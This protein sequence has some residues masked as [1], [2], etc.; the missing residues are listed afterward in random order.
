VADSSL[1]MIGQLVAQMTGASECMAANLYERLLGQ[2]AGHF[3]ADRAILRHYNHT[4][5]NSALIATWPPPRLPAGP[6]VVDFADD[7]V[8]LAAE[9]LRAPAVTVAGESASLMAVAPLLWGPT[10][11]GVVGL[12]KPVE[13]H[14]APEELETL[15]V[16]ASLF[17]QLQARFAAESRLHRLA[18]RDELTGLHNRRALTTEVRRR[19]REGQAGPVAALYID[20]DRLKSVNDRLGHDAGDVVIQTCARRLYTVA[21]QY[22]MVARVGGDE[23]VVVSRAAMSVDEAEAL[24]HSLC[25]AMNRSVYVAGEEITRTV[26]IGLAIGTPGADC[27]DDLLRRADHAALAVKRLGGNAFAVSSQ[28]VPVVS[29]M[30]RE[31]HLVESAELHSRH[32]H[33]ND[34]LSS[35]M[36]AS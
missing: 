23:F 19:L 21:G 36:T 8:M 7:A 35:E 26:S 24:A 10:T 29:R 12:T 33:E 32:Q 1:R 22:G 30:G 3:E 25:D 14:W 4:L 16:V 28:D 13:R 17:A 2:L 6:G 18:E 11:T 5:R 15:G 9:V 31:L 20:L 34:S 27:G